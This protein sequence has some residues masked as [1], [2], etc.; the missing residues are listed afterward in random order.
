MVFGQRDRERRAVAR[1]ARDG[2]RAAV[3][4]DDLLHHRQAQAQTG[5]FLPAGVGLIEP[6]PY[7]IQIFLRD[8]DAV[9]LHGQLGPGSRAPE[10][11]MDPAAVHAELEGVIKQ[12]LHD[13]RDEKDVHVDEDARLGRAADADAAARDHG[14]LV[15]DD[16]DEIGEVGILPVDLLRALIE[17]RDLKHA[18]DERRHLVRL[19]V[20]DIERRLIIRRRLRVLARVLAGGED[21]GRRRA[22]LVRGIGREALF[23]LERA[24]ESVEHIVK[25]CRELIDLVAAARVRQTDA[26]L[27][28]LPVGDGIGRG[29]ELA[30]GAQGAAGDEI[31][32]DDRQHEQHR[33]QRPRQRQND[34]HDA[35]VGI[36]VDDAAQPD[37]A[38]HHVHAHIV[39][40][41]F[42]VPAV[43][44]A[45]G[46]AAERQR[47][48]R[49]ELR[50][51]R[52]LQDVAVRVIEHGV[53]AAAVIMDAAEAELAV[54]VLDA[55][56]VVLDH[57]HEARLGVVRGDRAVDGEQEREHQRLD[58]KHHEREPAGDAQL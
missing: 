51:E 9:V 39:D 45:H 42:V 37:A 11:D 1:R 53:N 4:R 35:A 21:D 25:R 33:Q 23:S 49:R 18:A 17:P 10:R 47:L 14:L 44:E 38:D 8:T 20:D 46:L 52:A 40:V 12:V 7:F 16:G 50:R 13:A 41:I 32:A 24:L 2:D 31:P 56:G 22:Q 54:I 5:V 55:V 26:R 43:D 29:R 27:E 30:H 58:D 6:L 15:A 34:A 3:E 48:R 36:R 28:V 19:P 57:A